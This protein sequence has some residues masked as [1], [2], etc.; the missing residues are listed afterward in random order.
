MEADK[1][2]DV[3]EDSEVDDEDFEDNEDD[4]DDNEDNEDDEEDDNGEK[5]R[6]IDAHETNRQIVMGLTLLRKYS[7]KSINQLQ[8]ELE[9]KKQAITKGN[10]I[11][12][13][14]RS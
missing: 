4:E 7:R 8:R 10:K 5:I 1:E 3:N 6:I 11:E 9:W 12:K 2:S 14:S 13:N